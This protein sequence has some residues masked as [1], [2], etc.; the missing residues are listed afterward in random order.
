MKR[1]LTTAAVGFGLCAVGFLAWIYQ[2][3]K[4]LAVTDLSNSFSWGLYMGSFEFFIGLSSGGMLL[5]SIAYLWNVESLKPFVKLGALGSLASVVAAGVAIL[6]DLGKPF[7]VLQ[8]L[9]TPNVKSPLFWDVL[10]LGLYAV[11]CLTAVLLQFLPEANRFRFRRSF[12]LDCEVYSKRLSYV[13]LPFVAILNAVTTLMFAVQTSREWWHSAL[14]PADSVAVATALGLSFTMLLGLVTSGREG[15]S[16]WRTAFALQ[17]KISGVSLLAHFFFTILELVTIAWSGKAEGQHLLYLLF[18]TYGVLYFVELALPFVAM[19]IYF[20]PMLEKRRFLAGA[21]LLVILG[22][23]VHRMMLLL[24]AFNSIPLTI[25]VAG[26]EGT[27]W[28]YPIASGIIQPGQDIFVSYWSYFPSL[29]EWCVALLPVGFVILVLAGVMCL[30][31]VVP[32]PKKN[33]AE[34]EL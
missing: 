29:I 33:P 28:S 20:L 27:L 18:D 14:L 13:A 19:T 16:S 2:I 11:I 5:F 26:L 24:P 17:A 32:K 1:R 12:R 7:R 4:G 6:T 8:M 31:T 3:W 25:P 9:I 23:F 30:T 34:A 10:V 21:N 15:Y 22:S